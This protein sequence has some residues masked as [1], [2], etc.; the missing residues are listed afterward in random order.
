[1]STPL[2]DQEPSGNIGN[3]HWSGEPQQ[4]DSWMSNPHIIGLAIRVSGLC[5]EPH[6]IQRGDCTL[7]GKSFATIQKEIT[8]GYL[9]KTHIPE[10]TYA[11]RIRSKNA[12]LA[13][14]SAGSVILVP[15]GVSQATACDGIFY[16]IPA[17]DNAPN[18][19]PGLLP[20]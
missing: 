4:A 1:M 15:G 5:G 19:A 16:Q 9:E 8:L 7:C 14:M 6:Y 17:G 3:D 13:G 10:R 20:I 11:Q 2:I 12:F 18:P